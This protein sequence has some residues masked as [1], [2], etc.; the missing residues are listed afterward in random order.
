MLNASLSVVSC[1]AHQALPAASDLTASSATLL[2]THTRRHTIR[3]R[4]PLKQCHVLLRLIRIGVMRSEYKV[5]L[6]PA[7]VLPAALL[8]TLTDCPRHGTS[9]CCAACRS[10]YGS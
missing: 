6:H 1:S 10:G 7:T 4:L 3:L 2:I 5:S 8:L 9:W